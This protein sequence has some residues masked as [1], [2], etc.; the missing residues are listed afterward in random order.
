MKNGETFDELCFSVLFE[1]CTKL[2]QIFKS[3]VSLYNL[4]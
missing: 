1:S 2:P 3:A 4:M